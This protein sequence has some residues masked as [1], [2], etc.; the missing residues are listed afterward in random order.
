MN[1]KTR[2]RWRATALGGARKL[3]VASVVGRTQQTA[4]RCGGAL[5]AKRCSIL[6]DRS[7][8]PNTTVPVER[9]NLLVLYEPH[10]SFVLAR[11]GS[12]RALLRREESPLRRAEGSGDTVQHAV[13]CAARAAEPALPLPKPGAAKQL[14]LLNPQLLATLERRRPSVSRVSTVGRGLGPRN[15]DREP[16]QHRR[17][18]PARDGRRPRNSEVGSRPPQQAVRDDQRGLGEHHDVHDDLTSS[19]ACRYSRCGARE[20]MYTF[21]ARNVRCGLGRMCRVCA[22]VAVEVC[23][24][25]C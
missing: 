1:Q 6:C 15:A 20:L 9:C 17:D 5:R 3:V 16:N 23:V 21:A 25:I 7:N 8:T 2:S 11:G 18:R 22:W 4:V 19:A 24:V 12:G 10:L 14:V 13:A